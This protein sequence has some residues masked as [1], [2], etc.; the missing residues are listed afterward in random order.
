MMSRETR[1]F[2][3]T[4]VHAA[5]ADSELAPEHSAIS[6]GGGWPAG[7]AAAGAVL[8]GVGVGVT[9]VF[10]AGDV[11]DHYYRQAVTAAGSG[12]MAAIEAERFLEGQ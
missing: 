12:C 2:W 11:Q 7:L 10:A 6:A 5:T 9:G 8:A 4:L 1:R 3:M